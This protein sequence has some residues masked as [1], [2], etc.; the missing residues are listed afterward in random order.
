MAC[1]EIRECTDPACRLRMPIDLEL[2]AGAFCPLCGAVMVGVE[3]EFRHRLSPDA[4]CVSSSG[5]VAILD[6]I[7]SAHNVGAIFR[8]ADGA[9]VRHLYLCGITPS[10]GDNPAVAKTALGAEENVSW[11]HHLNAVI[12]AKELQIMGYDL[13]SV[14][15]TP[16]A[17]PIHQFHPDRAGERPMVLIIGNE[18]A[19]IDPGLIRISDAVVALPMAGA[20]ASLN[21][22]VAF[23]IAAYLLNF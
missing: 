22:A 23:G 1:F 2:H 18:R 13:I 17:I 21:V 14:E 12:S 9:G 10:P 6:N 19:G 11:S 15:C 3:P 8:T 5:T 16:E 4:Q 20:K 7:R